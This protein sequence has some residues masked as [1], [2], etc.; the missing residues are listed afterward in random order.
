MA[1]GPVLCACLRLC[2]IPLQAGSVSSQKIKLRH[3]DVL[4][5]DALPATVR[6]N[7][8]RRFLAEGF[9]AHMQVR[10]SH[11]GAAVSG[12][13]AI[14]FQKALLPFLSLSLS[15]SGLGRG[16]VLG[17]VGD[18]HGCKFVG[19]VAGARLAGRGSFL[20]GWRV[21]MSRERE[22][23]RQAGSGNRYHQNIFNNGPAEIPT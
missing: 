17:G 20:P 23:G 9:Q 19:G 18:G 2:P 6:L 7:A 1:A 14:G 12:L 4:V 5:V 11:R 3:G 8:M 10:R 22:G 13:R 15:L 21:G 16:V